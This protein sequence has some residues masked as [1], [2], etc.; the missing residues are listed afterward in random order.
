MTLDH[1]L[2]TYGTLSPG[3]SN[4]DQL[5]ALHGDWILGQVRGRVV[6]KQS[7]AAHGFPALTLQDGGDPVSV[8]LFC[9]S[10]LPDHWDRLDAF[11]GDGYARVKVL[12]ETDA[13]PVSAWIYVDASPCA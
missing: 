7:G 5:S 10:E 12:V 8:N 11:E 4:H 6:I 9:S 13:G 2:A 3:R 1:H